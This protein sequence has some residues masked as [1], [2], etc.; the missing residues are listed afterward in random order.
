MSSLRARIAGHCACARQRNRD[1]GAASR[2]RRGDN[3]SAGSALGHRACG[4]AP[5]SEIGSWIT[6]SGATMNWPYVHT[7]INH[8][9]IILVVMGAAAAVTA[10][11]LRRRGIWLYSVAS[12][13]LA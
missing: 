6:S 2:R 11:V 4:R 1:R 3:I 5:L 13:T 10:L 12:L 8:F 7:L 9:P